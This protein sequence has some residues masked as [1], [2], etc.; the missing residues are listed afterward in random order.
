MYDFLIKNVNIIDGKGSPS[1]NANLAILNDEIA[2]IGKEEKE[3]KQTLDCSGLYLCPGFIDIH[4]HTDAEMLKKNCSK[5]KLLQGITTDV[6]GNCGVGLFPLNEHKDLNIN[7]TIPVLGLVEE[8]NWHDFESYKKVMQ[9]KAMN[10]NLLFLQAHSPLRYYVLGADSSREATDDEIK[11]MCDLLDKSLSQGAIGFSSGLYYAPCLFASLKEIEALLRV[12]Q[13][14]NGLFAVHHRCEG[15]EIIPSVKEVLDLSLKTKVRLEISHLKAIGERNQGKIDTVLALIE[16]Y[17]EKGLEVNFDQYPYIFGSTSLYSILPPKAL[18][19]S[20]EDLRKALRNKETREEYKIAM[21]NETTWD[22]IYSLVGPKNI[23]VLSLGGKTLFELAEGGDPLDT[24]FDLLLNKGL[25]LVMEDDTQSD[26]NLTKIFMHD[27]MLFGTDA[28][29]S[30]KERHPRTYEATSH[31][32]K[33]FVK[34]K[35]VISIE[36]AV[37]KMTYLTAKKLNITDRGLIKESY[38][39]DLCIFDLNT[40]E[41]KHVFV[42]GKGSVIDQQLTGEYKGLVL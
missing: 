37:E 7:S 19:L 31:L 4:S 11:Q 40:V 3:S 25:S 22:N 27:L 41:I 12:V 14:H 13:K 1:Y 24:F 18:K 34:E 8:V 16:E 30:S 5:E 29:F 42:N 2:Y 38:K 17:R 35:K 20:E 6:S 15:D 23:R 26:E 36:K 28:L 32:I 21:R 39:A 10:T 33:N 9:S